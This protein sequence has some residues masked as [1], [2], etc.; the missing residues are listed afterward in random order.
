MIHGPYNIKFLVLL[1][2]VLELLISVF[3]DNICE[4]EGRN[5]INF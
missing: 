3:V 1:L 4:E 2:S 5:G